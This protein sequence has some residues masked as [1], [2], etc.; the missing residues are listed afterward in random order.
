M[1][2]N[3]RQIAC[4]FEAPPAAVLVAE[5]RLLR[6]PFARDRRNRLQIE[7]KSIVSGFTL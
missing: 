2:I 5:D 3:A 7:A 1:E 6:V 4:Y